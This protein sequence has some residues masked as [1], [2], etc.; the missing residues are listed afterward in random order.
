MLLQGVSGS[1]GDPFE[2]HLV[3]EAE[4]RDSDAHACHRHY[5]SFPVT[6]N[7]TVQ[8]K[9]PKQWYKN[10][11]NGGMDVSIWDPLDDFFFIY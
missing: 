11:S 1:V 7:M 10:T 3:A 5:D 9:R 6:Q 4:P 2:P 8:T